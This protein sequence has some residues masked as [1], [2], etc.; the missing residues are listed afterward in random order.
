[1]DDKFSNTLEVGSLVRIIREPYFGALA[2]VKELPIKAEKIETGAYV[3]VL[4]AEVE[5]KV[6]TV[7][8]AN[9]ELQG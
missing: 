6:V 3:R 2:Q 7:P 4:R 8:R 5:G 9:V 1:M